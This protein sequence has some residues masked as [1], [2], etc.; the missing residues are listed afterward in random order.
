[1][2]TEV[3]EP[4]TPRCGILLPDNTRCD[5]EQREFEYEQFGV[6]YKSVAPCMKCKSIW[7]MHNA[8]GFMDEDAFAA[9][10]MQ[11]AI[12]GKL[13]MDVQ[14]TDSNKV[15]RQALRGLIGG[16]GKKESV[17]LAGPTGTGKTFLAVH[18]LK[19]CIQKCGIS[20]LYAPE[21]ILVR[22]Y[23]AS[24]DFQ[25]VTRK[26]WGD[27]FL[28]SAKTATLL[29]LDDFGQN[30]NVTDGALDA[31]EQIIMYRYDAGLHVILTSNRDAGRLAEE[32]GN[33]IISRLRGMTGDK[34]II[35]GG[36]DWRGANEQ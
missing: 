25:N 7:N 30:R 32:R 11:A 27:S 12:L 31:I 17:V 34:F 2:T 35:L 18:A 22:A 14:K 20:G 5:E 9:K 15:A 16:C 36:S 29:V 13:N 21:H 1:M 19:T 28:Q 23:K 10:E 6:K 8:F 3:Q 33:R 26:K 24:N 4:L